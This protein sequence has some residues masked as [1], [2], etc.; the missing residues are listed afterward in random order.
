MKA[1]ALEVIHIVLPRAIMLGAGVWI[2]WMVRGI[3]LNEAVM[4]WRQ[5]FTAG[6]QAAR[7]ESDRIF[8][9]V[10]R[11]RKRRFVQ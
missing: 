11:D 3:R 6:Y 9:E 5:G 8:T 2:G 10:E 4:T 1:S 7:R